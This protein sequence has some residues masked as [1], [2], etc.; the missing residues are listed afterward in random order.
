[1]LAII[2]IYT[3]DP[4]KMNETTRTVLTAVLPLFGT[5][6]GTVLAFYFS[7]DNFEAATRSVSEMSRQLTAREKLESIPVRDKMILKDKM[8]FKKLP[9]DKIILADLLKEID[10][11]KKG[12][13]VPILN[14][15]DYPEY[16]IHRS[17]IDKYIADKAR[18][19]T[20]ATDLNKL[21]LQN[22]LDDDADLKKLFETSFMTVKEESSLATAK[23]MMDSTP[24]CQ[25]IF[26][27]K[28]GKRNEEVLGWI[29]NMT[30]IENAQV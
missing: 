16:I 28:G 21:T 29:T 19:G 17:A 27:T 13:R 6:V 3:S 12:S 18:A 7:K 30:I 23:D 26:I 5:W 24:D 11:K 2:L 10:K 8:F 25:D 4:T 15:S 14:D 9:A 1:M 20:T 22:L